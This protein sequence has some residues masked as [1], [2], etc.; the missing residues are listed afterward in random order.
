MAESTVKSLER[1]LE[2][3]QKVLLSFEKGK[4]P[5]GMLIL[6]KTTPA[7]VRAEIERQLL[8]YGLSIEAVESMGLLDSI[9]ICSLP[10]LEG[11][12]VE[13]KSLPDIGSEFL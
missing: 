3:L 10:W 8:T 13:N 1:Q 6:G 7:A 2:S 12:Y 11:R 5:S 4:F 9:S